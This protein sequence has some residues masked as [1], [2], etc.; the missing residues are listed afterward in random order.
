MRIMGLCS[1]I[2]ISILLTVSFFVLFAVQKTEMQGLKKFGRIIAVLLWISSTMIFTMGIFVLSTGHHPLF[3]K[4]HPMMC[5]K[6]MCCNLK[7]NFDNI[8]RKAAEDKT[9]QDFESN[10]VKNIPS[11]NKTN[12]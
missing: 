11:V 12:K 9:G 3:S 4:R 1:I 2:P 5:R 8:K 7:W 6:M 10:N